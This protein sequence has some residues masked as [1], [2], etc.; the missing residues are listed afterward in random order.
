MSNTGG[1]YF[2]TASAYPHHGSA[3]SN[4]AGQPAYSRAYQELLKS[5]S[6]AYPH[7][8]PSLAAAAGGF[9]GAT[10]GAGMSTPGTSSTPYPM[11]PTPG[12]SQ[13]RQSYA[14]PNPVAVGIAGASSVSVPMP[15]YANYL[16]TAYPGMAGAYPGFGMLPSS[17]GASAGASGH[18]AQGHARTRGDDDEEDLPGMDDD[19]YS[20]QAQFQTQSKADL[21]CVSYFIGV[22]D[23]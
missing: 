19:D 12:T 11:V 23:D 2:P 21:K 5:K 8:I 3:A 17:A 4:A 14:V 22:G 15:H 16:Q 13:A 18:G 20:A 1:S 7:A 10:P 6:E 9:G